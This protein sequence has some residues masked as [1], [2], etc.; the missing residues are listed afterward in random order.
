MRTSS[1]LFIALLCVSMEVRAAPKK[2]KDAE[3]IKRIEAILSQMNGLKEKEAYRQAL[4]D[5]RNIEIDLG[6]RTKDDKWLGLRPPEDIEDW[7]EWK[8][9]LYKVAGGPVYECAR[10]LINSGKYEEYL[11]VMEKHEEYEAERVRLAK[12]A[13]KET[14]RVYKMDPPKMSG[15]ILSGAPCHELPDGA[16]DPAYVEC[17]I[18]KKAVWA[19]AYSEGLNVLGQTEAD[20]KVLIGPDAFGSPGLLA[21]TLYHEGKHFHDFLRPGVDLKN[22]FADEVRRREKDKPFLE[23]VFDFTPEDMRKFESGLERKRALAARWEK[24]IARGLDPYK[25]EDRGALPKD[26]EYVFIKDGERRTLKEIFAKGREL[27]DSAERDAARKK[28]ISDFHSESGLVAVAACAPGLYGRDPITE[29]RLVGLRGRGPDF[30][31]EALNAVPPRQSWHG[32]DYELWIEMLQRLANGGDITAAWVNQG[33]QRYDDRKREEADR[34]A[35]AGLEKLA[36]TYGFKLEGV[37]YY[38]RFVLKNVNNRYGSVDYRFPFQR[39]DEAQAALFLARTCLEGRM[40]EP[41][42][43]ALDVLRRRI[44]DPAF[45]KAIT[46]GHGND[47]D[48]CY[49]YVM[50]PNYGY[51]TDAQGM[52]ELLAAMAEK[53]REAEDWIRKSRERSRR[54]E[55]ADREYREGQR[56]GRGRGDGSVDLTPAREALEKARREVH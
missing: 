39:L 48:W 3:G 9:L 22:E 43:E 53:Q 28:A 41:S 38:R 23:S 15:P 19:P 33:R 37:D 14:R 32:C 7:P 42:G 52:N 8:Q 55:A 50:L 26:E 47:A 35:L 27:K 40:A 44:A 12:D 25:V 24:D 17:H 56:D 5:K 46:M 45:R 29:E 20:G 34:E 16:P 11:R 13:I 30:Y 31:R 10:N 6:L 1:I 49:L 54:H 4:V 21:Y 51:L 2:P 18:G 36:A